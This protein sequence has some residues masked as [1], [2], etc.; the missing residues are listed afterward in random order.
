[1]MF[2][3]F[4]LMS[5][6][7]LF[8]MLNMVVANTAGAMYRSLMPL[9][10]QQKGAS[11]EEVGLFFT[12]SAVAPLLF[13]LLGG[14][15]SDSL[16]RL[17]AVAIGSLGGL[18]S[19]AVYLFAPTWGWLLLASVFGAI[20][21]SFVS[22]SYQAYVAE[23]TDEANLGKVYGL[24]EAIFTLV[25]I[26]GP[27][28]GGFLSEQYGFHTMFLVAGA[29]Y[30]AATVHRVMMALTARRQEREA[31]SAGAAKREKPSLKGLA[32][33]LRGLLGLLTAGGVVTWIFIS[34]GLTD[35][36][37]NTSY[38]FEPLYMQNLYGLTNTQIGW[39]SSLASVVMILL[40][41]WAGALSDKHGER[42]GI[43]GGFLLIITGLIT[44]LLARSFYGFVLAWLLYGAGSALIAPAHNS[45]IS[46]AVP[47]KLRGTAFGLFST[48][49]GVVALPMPYIGGLLWQHIAPQAPFIVPIFFM[50]LL[51]PFVWTKFRLPRPA[52]AAAEAAKD[53]PQAAP[54]GD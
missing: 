14:W 15:M 6:P 21:Y 51:L 10:V 25:G 17:Q 40:T 18:L 35:I 3:N 12:L 2:R 52:E 34:D 23:Q 19:Y 7:L 22:P 16:G 32:A 49:I 38:Q 27:P 50:T 46:K 36:A 9:Y 39:L 31:V 20:A 41:G 29:L 45:L 26:I 47:Q 4:Q 28:L 8:F 43:A 30:G 1:M 48:S 54:L 13:Q 11:V 42:V 44:F 37:F 33:S 24:S 53:T 5:R